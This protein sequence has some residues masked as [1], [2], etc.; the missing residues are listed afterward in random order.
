M[1]PTA[2]LTAIALIAALA[3]CGGDRP[4]LDSNLRAAAAANDARR[5]RQG[6]ETVRALVAAG[7]DV[8]IAD[9]DGVTPLTHARERGYDAIV[10]ILRA[11]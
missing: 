9:G 7:A 3:G 11:A 5:K 1:F 6:P 8:T 4:D 10:A 2:L